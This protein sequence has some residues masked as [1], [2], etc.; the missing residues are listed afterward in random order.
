MTV[1]MGLMQLPRMKAGRG[2]LL[3][4]SSLNQ[5]QLK[6]VFQKICSKKLM[7]TSQTMRTTLGVTKISD[8]VNF[9]LITFQWRELHLGGLRSKA[10]STL[11]KIYC[12][13]TYETSLYLQ[14]VS[15]VS[16]GLSWS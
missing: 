1:S 9:T 12:L 8:Y 16:A 5:Y 10:A 2:P 11:S 4:Q 14:N 13:L 7:Q 6:P 15:T 3:N